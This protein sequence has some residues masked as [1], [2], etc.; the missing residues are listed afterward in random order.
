MYMYGGMFDIRNSYHGLQSPD[1]TFHSESLKDLS[2]PYMA[3][4]C[5]QYIY[6]RDSVASR[7]WVQ[8]SARCAASLDTLRVRPTIPVYTQQ[9]LRAFTRSYITYCTRIG[10]NDTN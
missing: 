2:A 5:L 3:W 9:S 7:L 1:C 4:H 10:Y 8:T 6:S